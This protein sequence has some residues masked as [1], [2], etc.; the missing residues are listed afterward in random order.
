MQMRETGIERNR[1][2]N[3]RTYIA[4]DLKSFYASVECRE[5][6][7][8]PMDANLVVADESRTD[9]TICLAVT[10]PLK[11]C[12]I[13][14]RS[15]LFEVKQRI[16]EVNAERRRSLGGGK[17]GGKSCFSSELAANRSLEAD[18]I[19]APPRMA[20][21]IEYSTRIYGIYAKYVSPD[22]IVVY[23]IDE[24]FMDVTEYLGIHKLSAAGLAMKIILDVLETTGI[25]ATA[26]IGTNLYLAKVAMDIMAKRARPDGNGVRMASLDEMAYR[27]ML[28][29]HRPLTDF[30]R[31]G[32]GYAGRLEQ[33][34]IFTM[35]DLARCSLENEEKL[36]RIFGKNAE[37]LIDH[38]W[39]CEPATVAAIK[40]YRSETSSLSSGQVLHVPY[41]CCKA[42]LVLAEMADVLSLDLVDKGLATDQITVTIGYDTEN[43]SIP[44]RR[45]NCH[46]EI[47]RDR[48]GRPIPKHSHG[49][50]NLGSHTSSTRKILDAALPLFDRIADKGLLVRRLNISACRLVA[51]SG[52]RKMEPKCE[53]L[54]L[55][56]DYA[57]K[58][59][60]REREE[61]ALERER[62]MQKALIAIKNKFGKN[63]ILKGINFEDGATARDRNAQIGGHKA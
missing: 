13:S 39:G 46:R 37:L 3:G 19:I 11:A 10:P 40:A 43:V 25:T 58:E 30:W 50:A 4:I 14:G 57:E 60:Q 62:K 26:G 56:A 22:D 59:A 18:F 20:H 35:G 28:W 44:E 51:E 1:I 38:A 27:R 16:R 31:V 17:F 42:R 61:L 24:V 55:F 9:K 29:S 33:N 5:R 41:E 12:G 7:L 21:Y 54:D 2:L 53:Q 63:S 34:G 32:P 47:V 45:R 6:G 23:S 52:I 48:Y 15:R 36:Y 8:D 49:T